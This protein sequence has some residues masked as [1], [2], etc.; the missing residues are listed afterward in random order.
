MMS[1]PPLPPH[2]PHTQ[3]YDQLFTVPN[4]QNLFT[5]DNGYIPKTTK[6]PE[7]YITPPPSLPHPHTFSFDSSVSVYPVDTMIPHLPP[8][9]SQKQ[10]LVNPGTSFEAAKGTTSDFGN[11]F[12]GKQQD[13]DLSSL[14]SLL[15]PTNKEKED[16]L[17]DFA[18]PSDLTSLFD[19]IPP[20]PQNSELTNPSPPKAE[21][22]MQTG[23]H[24]LPGTGKEHLGETSKVPLPAEEDPF[25][26][27]VFD[28]ENLNFEPQQ[29]RLYNSGPSFDELL[30]Q[31]GEASPV[32]SVHSPEQSPVASL[33]PSV[34]ESDVSWDDHLKEL[35]EKTFD[36]E[37]DY[38]LPPP[39]K[40]RHEDTPPYAASPPDPY[41]WLSEPRKTPSP[42]L[43]SPSLPSPPASSPPSPPEHK[44][45][46]LLP[47]P[48]VDAMG[49][50]GGNRTKKTNNSAV[51]FGKHESEIIH[52]LLI[53][54]P[55]VASKPITRD[56]LVLMPVEE[57]NQMLEQA[58]LTEIEVAFMKEWR[59]RG[60][61]K[62]AAQIARKRKRD[63]LSDLD[64][65]VEG[66]RRQKVELQLRYDRLRSEISTLK[67]RALAA[68][69]S[70]YQRYRM[71]HGTPVSRETHLIHVDGSKVMLVPRINS[72]ILLVK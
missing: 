31:L 10:E 23:I 19:L 5:P 7:L 1:L 2:T 26:T 62:S 56:K 44:P 43:P 46:S 52:K 48:P 49:E 57:F 67:E 4:K 69:D 64:L 39:A 8:E 54:Q 61:N 18:I 58:N 25:I 36:L 59:R 42:S 41:H 65:E 21:A 11:L 50:R 55:G 34:S 68:E 66:L 14:L 35:F 47:Q 24:L 70:V 51:L 45:V 40:Q 27:G 15:T 32:Q 12:S 22:N 60:K 33:L 17:L 30:S 9:S 37:T 63:E 72:G 20:D 16:P 6:Y 38:M 13:A 29:S 53:P 3:P 28:E 71:E